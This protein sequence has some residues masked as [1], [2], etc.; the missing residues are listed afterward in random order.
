MDDQTIVVTIPNVSEPIP[1]FI[2]FRALG[3]Q[4]AE[5]IEEICVHD[6]GDQDMADLLRPS[7]VDAQGTAPSDHR[8]PD[9]SRG[10][11]HRCRNP[12]HGDENPIGRRPTDHEE[13][14]DGS[15]HSGS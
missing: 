7:R 1:L 8:N 5:E 4:A 13:N 12:L 10:F 11:D 15:R 2:L 6:T 3:L 14:A 9:A